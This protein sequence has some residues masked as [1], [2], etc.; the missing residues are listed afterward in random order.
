MK[1][2]VTRQSNGVQ[3]QVSEVGEHADQLMEAFQE[4]REGRCS[5]PTTEYDKVASIDVA[6]SEDGISLTVTSK[7]GTQIDVAEIEKCLAHTKQ[8]IE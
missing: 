4:C 7:D 3:I 1:S 6:Q 2:R 8:R 5:C